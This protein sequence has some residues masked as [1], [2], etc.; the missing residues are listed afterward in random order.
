[1]IF[2]PG[3][4]KPLIQSS[5]SNFVFSIFDSDNSGTID[6]N[7]FKNVLNGAFLMDIKKQEKMEGRRLSTTEIKTEESINLEKLYGT[8]DVDN[9]GKI[10]FDEFTAWYNT[11]D[12][13]YVLSKS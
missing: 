5:S 2:S 7:E 8:I 3:F 12:A 6:M 13:E 4:T 10:S 9:N 11:S 1:M